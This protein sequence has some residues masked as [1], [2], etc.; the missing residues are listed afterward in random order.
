[1]R[2]V[3]VIKTIKGHDDPR[4]DDSDDPKWRKTMDIVL[5]GDVAGNE[6]IAEVVVPTFLS[7]SYTVGRRVA[8]TIQ[9]L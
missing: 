3:G 5:S 2:F 9:P 1:M 4:D 7:R 8:L 6:V